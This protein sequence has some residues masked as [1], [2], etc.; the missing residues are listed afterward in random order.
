MQQFAKPG[1]HAKVFFRCILF[2]SATDLV[3]LVFGGKILHEA[4]S[5]IA[6]LLLFPLFI[7]SFAFLS[8]ERRLALIGFLF[9]A[10]FVLFALAVPVVM[11]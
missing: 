2:A 4:S 11:E 10:F 6:C 3:P 1:P 5:T 7:L 9:I 8:S